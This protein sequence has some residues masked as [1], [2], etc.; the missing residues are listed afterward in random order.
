MGSANDNQRGPRRVRDGYLANLADNDFAS[1]ASDEA[2]ARLAEARNAASKSA[3]LFMLIG[4]ILAGLYFLRL[5]DVAGDLKFGEYKLSNLPFGLF[6]LAFCALAVSIVSLIRFGD[7][8]AYD[9]QLKLSCEQRYGCDCDL[10]YLVFPNQHGWGEPFAQ[11]AHVVKIGLLAGFLRLVAFGLINLF[12]LAITLAPSAT[13]IDFFANERWSAD[14]GFT[15][16][17]QVIIGF[18]LAANIATLLLT[19]WIRLLDRD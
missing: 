11:M 13:G 15:T 8:R 14:S 6:V 18:F 5:Q 7:S 16:T 1:V 4:A 12:L 10:R 9:R 3:N 17:R 2:L 19:F